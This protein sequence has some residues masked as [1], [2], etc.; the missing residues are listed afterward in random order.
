VLDFDRVYVIVEYKDAFGA[1]TLD[2]NFLCLD[3]WPPVPVVAKPGRSIVLQDYQLG[4]LSQHIQHA[5]YV[6]HDYG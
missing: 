6:V 3:Y 1:V 4:D 2:N 5:A